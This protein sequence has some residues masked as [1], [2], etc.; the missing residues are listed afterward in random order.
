[1]IL[2]TL[3]K[4]F[5]QRTHKKLKGLVENGA[6]IIDVRPKKDFE[7]G[8]IEESINIPL[9]ELKNNLRRIKKDHVIIT[10]SENGYNSASAKDILEKMGHQKVYNAGPWL[11]LY[12][13]I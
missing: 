4:I 6:Q 3:K 5:T 13:V 1:M 11:D 2:G 7:F 9:N 12:R 10:C 8:Y